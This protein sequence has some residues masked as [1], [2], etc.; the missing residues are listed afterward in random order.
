MKMLTQVVDC[1][2]VTQHGR[3]WDLSMDKGL[4]Y[5]FSRDREAL[6]TSRDDHAEWLFYQV[7][8]NGQPGVR[9]ACKVE[10]GRLVKILFTAWDPHGGFR[11]DE[12]SFMPGHNII[13]PLSD[14][15][16]E[17]ARKFPQSV[18]PPSH[19]KLMVQLIT[20]LS[21]K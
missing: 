3:S 20:E 8:D 21:A 1:Q 11:K 16:Y 14:A 10:Q 15:E 9:Y 13:I 4:L 2:V 6:V 7:W 5:S 12:W 19:E 17:L 18:N